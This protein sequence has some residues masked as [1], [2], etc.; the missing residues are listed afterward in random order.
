MMVSIAEDISEYLKKEIY[1]I[2]IAIDSEFEEA[3]DIKTE[4]LYIGKYCAMVS[5]EHALSSREELDMQELYQYPLIM[6][7]PENIGNSYYKMIERPQ[8]SSPVTLTA[9]DEQ[10]KKK[11]FTALNFR[12]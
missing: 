10:K 12:Q 4:P 5:M 6:I 8:S 7:N 9:R 3:K 1:D 2:A 11:T